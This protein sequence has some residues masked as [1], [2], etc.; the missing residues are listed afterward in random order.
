VLVLAPVETIMVFGGDLMLNGISPKAK[1]LAGVASEF[2]R[3]DVALANVEIPLT[4][5]RTRTRLKSA[6]EIRR[7]DQFVLKADPNH[8]GGLKDAGFDLVSLANNHAM[9]YG[10][11]GL[12]QTTSLLEKA[13]IR[14]AGAGR[15]DVAYSA[16][17]FETRSGVRVALLSALAFI[18]RSA[19]NKCGPASA[20][21]S[22]VAVIRFDGQIG[23]PQRKWLKQWVTSARRQADLVIVGL[24]WGIEK[25]TKPTAWQVKLGRA[26]IDAGA[27]LVW[28]HH[29]HVLQPVEVYRGKPILYSTGNLVSPLSGRSALFRVRFSG[30]RFTGHQLL[31]VILRNGRTSFPRK[32]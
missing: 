6:E 17:V 22:G 23:D 15:K 18:S 11:A 12:R 14:H 3:A 19:Q 30:S 7:R 2:R 21:E 1:P 16:S 20:K 9:D 27:D 5:A 29:P 4:T 8:I 28:G 32:S 26:T 31:P 25:Q 13:S 24:H 10:E